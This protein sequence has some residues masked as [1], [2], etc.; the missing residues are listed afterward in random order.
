MGRWKPVRP[1]EAA[2]DTGS[3]QSTRWEG[4]SGRA[5]RTF[6]RMVRRA[7]V[8]H[9]LEANR[10][11]QVGAKRL[12]PQ[13]DGPI[14]GL[15]GLCMADTPDEAATLNVGT[16]LRRTWRLAGQRRTGVRRLRR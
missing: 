3:G 8:L 14:V 5:A 4:D 15:D 7:Q 2:A 1:P 13:L 11:Q 10:L 16:G 9:S 6:A 12:W